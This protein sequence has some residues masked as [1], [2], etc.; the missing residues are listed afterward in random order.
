MCGPTGCC[1]AELK[2]VNFQTQ[3]NISSAVQ[4][5]GLIY[6][7]ICRLIRLIKIRVKV[8]PTGDQKSNG[9]K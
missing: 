7:A 4:A 3:Y 2:L 9:N 1:R 6:A 5:L 8:Q